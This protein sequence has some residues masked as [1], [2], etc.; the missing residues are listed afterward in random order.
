MD[1]GMRIIRWD[2]NSIF[3][4]A[5]T[6]GSGFPT[7]KAERWFRGTTKKSH[8][9]EIDMPNAIGHYNMCMGGIDKM[10]HLIALH[11]CQFKLRRWPMK[12][13]FHLM[14]L[15]MCNA[16]L[17]YQLEHK[18]THPNLKHLDL[19]TFKR[20]VSEC[21]IK[22]NES[23][24]YRR[25]RKGPGRWASQ[26]PRSLRFDGEDHWPYSFLDILGDIAVR[27]VINS[28]ICIAFN[29]GLIYA[30]GETEIVS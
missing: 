20:N 19:Y 17:L 8:K 3:N 21:W 30:V 23:K 29:V 14:D 18:Q 16:W 12:V 1:P 9:S 26:V 11:Q 27:F 6:F 22:K 4:L 7:V 13:F 10:D 24:T 2:D 15:T 28:Q 5:N 25:L